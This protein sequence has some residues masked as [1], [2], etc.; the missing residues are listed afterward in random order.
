MTSSWCGQFIAYTVADY[1]RALRSI[2][3]LPAT[4]ANGWNLLMK[5]T[6]IK[7]GY[8][9]SIQKSKNHQRRIFLDNYYRERCLV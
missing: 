7:K 2:K 9:K 6:N 5:R 8:V 4:K 1:N 3:F